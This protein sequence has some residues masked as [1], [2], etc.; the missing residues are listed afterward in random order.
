MAVTDEDRGTYITENV[1]ADLQYVLED[2]GISLDLQYRL[3]QHYNT[4]RVFAAIGDTSADV[5]TALQTDFALDPAASAANRATLAK[6][7][8]AWSLAKDLA[9]KEKDL[10]AET[11]I[12]GQPRILQHSKRQAMVRAVERAYGQL[13]DSEI[14]ANEYLASW[15]RWKTESHWRQP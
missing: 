2:T 15:K 11:K 4:L 13:Q 12:L 8:S 7:V 9:N 5:R 10:L 14:P 3:T 1:A 6:L